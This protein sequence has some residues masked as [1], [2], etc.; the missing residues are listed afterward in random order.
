MVSTQAA[1]PTQCGDAGRQ[2]AKGCCRFSMQA[3][4]SRTVAGHHGR[5]RKPPTSPKKFAWMQ[6]RGCRD[7]DGLR[8]DVTALM[9]LNLRLDVTAPS[10]GRWSEK[11]MRILC[12]GASD[13]T[14]RMRAS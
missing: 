6:T 11:E 5:G 10:G 7:A 1:S 13:A 4:V 14:H 8:L 3:L 12:R 2:G 9:L